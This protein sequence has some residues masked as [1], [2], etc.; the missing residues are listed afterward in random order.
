VKDLKGSRDHIGV[1]E[2][3]G[4][5]KTAYR[6]FGLK[7]SVGNLQKYG[8]HTLGWGKTRD[9]PLHDSVHSVRHAPFFLGGV[10]CGDCPWDF[11]K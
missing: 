10:V 6:E 11:Q 3:G 4:D 1:K 2:W 9:A 8:G 7:G 5:L